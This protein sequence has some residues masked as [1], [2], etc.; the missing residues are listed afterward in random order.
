[1]E[2]GLRRLRY[3]RVLAEELNFRRSAERLGITQP[4]LSRAIALLEE[5][6][7]ATLL[8]RSRRGVALTA[9]GRSFA[10][11]ADGVLAALDGAVAQARKVADG[12]AGTLS[13]GYTDTAVA[14]RLPDIVRSFRTAFPELHVHLVQGYT[15]QQREWLEDGRLDVA[16][17]T[18][19]TTGE[20]R[21]A[22]TV[23]RDAYT[24]ILPGAHPLAAR[25]SLTLADLAGEPFVLGDPDH[26][27]VYNGDFLALCESAG[28]SPRVVQSAP[29]SRG[30]VGLVSCG[31]GVSVQTASLARH[32][33]E[34]VAFRP[35]DRCPARIVTQAV[36]NT[37]FV[38]PAKTR[39]VEHLRG[40]D[41]DADNAA[42][43]PSG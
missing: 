28:F 41:I 38:Q 13:I 30:I 37:R 35:L 23:Q 40:Y 21:G 42:G 25:A 20:H 16:F 5:D 34:R 33:D 9:A 39:L 31:M 36:W 15:R 43:A 32:G 17:M 6:V 12:Q 27:S 8:E 3:F 14:G 4:A 1:M 19:P 22:I 2:T 10:T 26:W 18:G 24:A 29:D 7:G 11:G